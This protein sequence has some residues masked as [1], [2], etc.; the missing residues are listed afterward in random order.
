MTV[1][2]RWLGIACIEISS[3]G[4]V[5]LIDPYLSRIPPWKAYLGHIE[6]DEAASQSITRCDYI[7]VTHSHFDHLLDAPPIARRTGARLF[8][9]PNTARLSIALGI[10]PDK[11]QTVH[12]GDTL[13]LGNFAVRVFPFEHPRLPGYNP[14][15]LPAVL[16]PPLSAR[17][18]RMDI[19]YCYYIKTG[20]ASF[21][22]DAGIEPSVDVQAA[23]LF[24][25][26][27]HDRGYYHKLL[28]T[29]RPKQVV[30]IHWDNL[31]NDTDAR[32]YF[33]PP[34]LEW[35]PLKRI[36]FAEFTTTIHAVAPGV[37]VVIP[38]PHESHLYP[39]PS[40]PL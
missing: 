1:S 19:G 33:A 37:E 16:K 21:L 24:T 30:P 23:V 17:D 36:D 3:G 5:L 12:S 4:E 39:A 18:Y 9:S 7:L 32:P 20:G 22:T 2:W 28:D 8:G 26:P 10:S 25:Q 35:P 13:T 14:G 27:Y 11:V 15:E 29:V 34:E 40:P 31:F 6:P 38:E